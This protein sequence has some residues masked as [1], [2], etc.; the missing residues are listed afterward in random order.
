MLLTTEPNSKGL[1]FTDNAFTPDGTQMIYVASQSIYALDMTTYKSRKLVAGPVDDVVVG[2]KSPIVY[3]M[4]TGDTSLYAVGVNTG[5]LLK[6]TDLPKGA[7]ISTLNSDETLA[8]GTSSDVE[9]PKHPEHA[10]HR[11]TLI[12]DRLADHVPMTLFTVNLTTAQVNPILHSTDWL[13]HPQFS[14]TDPTLLMYCH[15]G[16]WQKVDRIWTIRADGSNNK[17]IHQRTVNGEIAGHE[18]WDA[19]GVTIWYDLQI[20]RG[21]NF[22]LASYNTVTGARTWYSVDRDAWSIH[23][24]VTPS[25]LLMAGD[26]AGEGNISRSKNARWIN[27]F[28]PNQSLVPT[29][30]D[31]TKLV[32]SGFLATEHLANMAHHNY[33][34]IE[35]NVRFSPDHKL[36]IFT[37]TMSGPNVLG[38]SYI[39]AVEVAKAPPPV[40]AGGQ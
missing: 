23:Y 33:S 31:Q 26:G 37:S 24:A 13:N 14:P 32:Q 27:L 3:F 28:T 4:R 20:P 34:E 1:Y 6:L 19:D 17:L 39:F 21:Q 8:A 11:A 15:E 12:D 30:I 38:P 35:P 36:V 10:D 40:A 29:E 2:R 16:P 22:Y 9:P 5:R 7:T 25:H 18:F